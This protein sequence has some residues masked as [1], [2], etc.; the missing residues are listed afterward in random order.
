LRGVIWSSTDDDLLGDRDR[1]SLVGGGK[2]DTR[3]G[4]V[5]VV[6]GF[7]GKVDLCHRSVG[8]DDKVVA[9]TWSVICLCKGAKTSSVL[10]EENRKRTYGGSIRAGCVLIVDRVLKGHSTNVR[11]TITL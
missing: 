7:R 9:A 4:E 5:A 8:Q 6:V 3:R 2:C 11:N 1:I 10:V